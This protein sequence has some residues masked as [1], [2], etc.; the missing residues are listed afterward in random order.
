MA[1]TRG[2]E[3]IALADDSRWQDIITSRCPEEMLHCIHK[4]RKIRLL[5][6]KDLNASLL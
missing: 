3:A 2:A 6:V 4:A 1:M 5:S